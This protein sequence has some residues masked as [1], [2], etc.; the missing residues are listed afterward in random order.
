MGD[1][2]G[3]FGLLLMLDFPT[4]TSLWAYSRS[5]RV[6]GARRILELMN[7]EN[8]L[9]QNLAGY[10]GPMRGEVEFRNVTF[11]DENRRPV[12]G[13]HLLQGRARP[14]GGHRRPD[15]LGQDHACR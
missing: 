5:P 8:N 9:D 2:V 3:Y 14:D 13:A 11:Q 10:S 6:A 7:R 1:V 12:A 15:R 4:F